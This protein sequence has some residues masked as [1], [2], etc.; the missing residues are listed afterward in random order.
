MIVFCYGQCMSISQAVKQQETKIDI[1][2][3]FLSN[4]CIVILQRK[5][6]LFDLKLVANTT[7]SFLCKLQCCY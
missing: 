4:H 5:K 2:V 6:L 7:M 1:R 3:L